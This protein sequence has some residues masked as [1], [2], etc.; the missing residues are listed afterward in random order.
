MVARFCARCGAEL[1]AFDDHGIA[2]R[3]C[4]ACGTV[5][6][7]NAKPCAGTLITRGREVLLVR[8]AIAP[9]K[10]HW[11]IVG[12]Y[13]EA[14]EH[15]E[16]GARREAREETGLEVELLHLL[17]MRL[18]RYEGEGWTLNMYYVAR[19]IGGAL[20]PGDDAV[21]ARWFDA[22]ALPGNLAFPNHLPAVL[23]DWREYVARM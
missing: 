12:G 22:D 6:Y 20:E 3:R 10:D 14:W 19:A 8:R 13:L 16:E 17:P 2:R 9:F 5:A 11:D 1:I 21:E 4:P 23:H 18:D 15:P 7:E